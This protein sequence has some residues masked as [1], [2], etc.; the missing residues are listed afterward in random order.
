VDL[1]AASASASMMAKY[2]Y[3]AYGNRSVISSTYTQPFGFSTKFHD[4]ESGF[5]YFGRRCYSPVLG[6][7]MSRDPVEELGG[8]GLYSYCGSD[9]PNSTDP[10]GLSLSR[11][12]GVI[13]PLWPPP[14]P[15]PFWPPL[16]PPAPSTPTASEELI[17]KCCLA[18][19]TVLP[20]W[21]A[22]VDTKDQGLSGAFDQ[23]C[24]CPDGETQG[25]QRCRRHIY[26]VT[27]LWT[28][29]TLIHWEPRSPAPPECAGV[30]CPADEIRDTG[31]RVSEET[32]YGPPQCSIC[33]PCAPKRG[34]RVA[35]I[36]S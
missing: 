19:P 28:S 10:I 12:P 17:R 33:A 32:R 2:Q 35:G 4:A 18:T 24:V 26:K 15:G 13:G 27:L 9:P 14:A 7:W 31:T 5:V 22:V 3:D 11:P 34:I 23:T 8:H 25:L 16:T 30:P 29:T 20:E 21:S 36:H 1:A 6:R